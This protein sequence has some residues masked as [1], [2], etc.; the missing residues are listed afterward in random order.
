MK[1]FLVVA[2]LLASLTDLGAQEATWAFG[3]VGGC[4]GMAIGGSLGAGLG[5]GRDAGLGSGIGFF[6]VGGLAATLAGI[7]RF[8]EGREL[9]GSDLYDFIE[10]RD[11]WAF[12]PFVG[13]AVLLG[14]P[15]GT[16]L[17]GGDAKDV[18]LGFVGNLVGGVVGY[19]V[20]DGIGRHLSMSS[21]PDG[22]GYVAARFEFGK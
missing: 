7:K 9:K 21:L 1:R 10:G 20:G 22:G 3:G 6:A 5:G 8:R 19:N 14:A 2:I 16:I 17:R 15:L 13:G 18:V 4:M 12:F 11:S